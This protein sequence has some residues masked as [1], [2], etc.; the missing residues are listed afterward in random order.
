[1]TNN[2]I[3]SQFE[4]TENGLL[5]FADYRAHGG[6][7][8]VTHVEA[9]PALRGTGATSRLMEDI[10]AFARTNDARIVPRCS[11][12]VAWFKRHKDAGD[13]IG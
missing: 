1:M 8:V 9:E 5:A 6:R 10:V 13:I 4:R 11:Y 3:Q 12:A 7:Y 2:E